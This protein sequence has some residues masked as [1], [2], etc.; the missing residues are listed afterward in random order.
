MGELHGQIKKL[1]LIWTSVLVVLILLSLISGWIIF[2]NTSASI[3]GNPMEDQLSFS[4][5]SL[6][7]IAIFIVCYSLQKRTE[8]STFVSMQSLEGVVERFDAY[9][10][11]LI[12]KFGCFGVS[13]VWAGILYLLTANLIHFF[14]LFASL[15]LLIIHFPRKKQIMKVIHEA[16]NKS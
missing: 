6:A 14:I 8:S 4:V 2:I 9:T 15:L 16:F 12:V 11:G 1:M 7:T 10:S 5:I 3:S 13:G